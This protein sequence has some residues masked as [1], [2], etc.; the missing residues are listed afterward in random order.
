VVNLAQKHPIGKP[1]G[2]ENSGFFT[3]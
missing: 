1:F 2:Y 3:I